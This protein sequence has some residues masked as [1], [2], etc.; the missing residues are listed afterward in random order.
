SG[1]SEA[2]FSSVAVLLSLVPPLVLSCCVVAAAVR[3]PAD[4]AL[5]CAAAGACATAAGLVACGVAAVCAC[6]AQPA[7]ANVSTINAVQY[8][9]TDSISSASLQRIPCTYEAR[10][11]ISCG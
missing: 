1:G 6:R 4:G 8:F 3:S 10:S 9:M 2:T 7:N 5:G 11:R